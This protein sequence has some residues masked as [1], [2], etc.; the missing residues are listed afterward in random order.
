MA[1]RE[2]QQAATAIQAVV[3]GRAA[4]KGAAHSD[5]R[6]NVSQP[7]RYMVP[8]ARP[9]TRLLDRQK[10]LGSK[11]GTSRSLPIIKEAPMLA[12]P[13]A[14]RPRRIPAV[15]T[16][17]VTLRFFEAPTGPPGVLRTADQASILRAAR[18][19]AEGELAPTDL[20]AKV[21]VGSTTHLEGRRSGPFDLG[22]HGGA[23]GGRLQRQVA[24]CAS[25]PV[26]VTEGW[27]GRG[28][29]GALAGGRAEPRSGAIQAAAIIYLSPGGSKCARIA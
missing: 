12:I 20:Y 29:R 6:P 27:R 25:G 4:R 18:E 21:R 13:A 1:F 28:P 23:R 9:P 7:A 24:G 22:S 8:K 17:K 10:A 16:P 26:A 2:K 15:H 14:G 11:F 19:L 3:R 5:G